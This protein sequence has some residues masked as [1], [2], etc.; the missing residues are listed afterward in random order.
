MDQPAATSRLIGP[1]MLLAAAAALAFAVI[2]LGAY[3]RLADAGLGCPDWPGC[4]GQLVGVP[5]TDA[6][7]MPIDA[8]RAWIEVSHRY[9]AALL[10]LLILAAVAS[11]FLRPAPGRERVLA[12]T[13]LAM[14]CAQG[15]LGALTVTERLMP[16]IVAAHLIGGMLILALLAAYCARTFL[17]APAVAA[18]GR[19][20]QM[21]LVGAALALFGQLFLGVWVSANYAALA[22]GIEYPTCNGDWVPDAGNWEALALNRQLGETS[23]GAPVSGAALETVHWLH[24]IGAAT[25]L[26]ALAAAVW[27]LAAAGLKKAAIALAGALSLQFGLGIA[28]VMSALALPV[29]LAHNAGAA[30][31]VIALA[32][33]SA[34]VF[35]APASPAAVK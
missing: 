10:G 24:R 34:P 26:V 27:G 28:T 5:E 22:C 31:L 32:A 4:Y 2:V 11:A 35:L 25:A 23:S 14:V 20:L 8:T 30:L 18:G 12:A 9:L 33:A 15:L 7:G 21:L 19:R 17:P 16:A 13:L 1:R 3:V 29:A 6:A